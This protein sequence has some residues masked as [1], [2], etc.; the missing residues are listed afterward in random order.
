MSTSRI[1]A[2]NDG[3]GNSIKNVGTGTVPL[4]G[5]R[6]ERY[7]S[8]SYDD[9]K[10]KKKKN[11]ENDQEKEL[12]TDNDDN[13]DDDD[14]ESTNDNNSNIKINSSGSRKRR[15]HYHHRKE[16]NQKKHSRNTSNKKRRRHDA[17]SRSS[18]SSSNVSSDSERSD[19]RSNNDS[20]T[21]DN[22]DSNDSDDDRKKRSKKEKANKKKSKKKLL[23]NSIKTD[24]IH[25]KKKTTIVPLSQQQQDYHRN[26]D[27]EERQV[28]RLQARAALIE[29]KFGYTSEQNPF[30]DPNLMETF[31]W[32]KKKVTKKKKQEEVSVDVKGSSSNTPTIQVND[33]TTTTTTGKKKTKD[34]VSFIQEIDKVRDRRQV[35]EEQRMEMERIKDEE[36]RMKEYEYYDQNQQKEELFHLQ[37]NKI[38]S[39]IRLLQHREKPIDIFVKHILLFGGIIN[40]TNTDT[41]TDNDTNSNT[42]ITKYKEQ[43]NVMD[44]AIETLEMDIDEPYTILRSLQLQELQELL[45]DINT[46][47]TMERELTTTTNKNHD[48]NSHSLS[49]RNQVLIQYW[50]NM[51]TITMDEIK[52]IQTGGHNTGKHAKMI[53][54]ISNIFIDQSISDLRTMTNEIQ[55]QIQQHTNNNNINPDSTY[56]VSY[57]TFVL[58]QIQVY[59]AKYELSELHTKMLVH[60]LERLEQKK[61]ELVLLSNNHNTNNNNNNNNISDTTIPNDNVEQNDMINEP[62]SSIIPA[63]VHMDMM[64]DLEE[65]LGLTNEVSIPSSFSS[66]YHNS[67]ND[68]RYRPRKPRY[69]NRVKSGY[70]WSKYNQTHYDKDNPPP[71]IVQGYKFNIF[72]PDLIDPTITPQFTL[73]PVTITTKNTVDGTITK[74]TSSEY[75]IIRFH[76]GPPYEDLAFQIVN[77]EWNRSRKRGYKCTF[78]RGV[79]SLYF[80]FTTHWYRK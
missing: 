47:R 19:S 65:E 57:W 26:D 79:L 75:C 51:Y 45:T 38:R 15:H 27:H 21:S 32:N 52:M 43:Y 16:S 22:D 42:I 61:Q 80:N 18:S 36:S 7:A 53:Q 4:I 41:D 62:S 10:K 39:M 35:R 33:D 14:H 29:T 37:Q 3:I 54:D 78:E 23:K 40:H 72:Y 30:N 64:G 20:S 67:S 55:Q 1:D 46:F 24:D 71:K 13:N 73:E 25:H 70:D 50:D 58:E 66:P 49:D 77:R 17:I 11:R 12:L 48:Q 76:A 74:Q 5:N 9:D 59:I 44:I 28:R 8:K 68:E 34:I 2:E 60:Q 56:D 69:Y 6:Q 63:N 31:V